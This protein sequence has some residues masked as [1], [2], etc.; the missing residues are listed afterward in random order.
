MSMNLK[1]YEYEI[2]NPITSNCPN[3]DMLSTN[4]SN[5]HTMTSTQISTQFSEPLLVLLTLK[6]LMFYVTLQ[7][8]LCGKHDIWHNFQD[9][10]YFQKKN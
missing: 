4:M 8:Q 6:S 9:E 1:C 3:T 2:I 5:L 10:N 7:Q